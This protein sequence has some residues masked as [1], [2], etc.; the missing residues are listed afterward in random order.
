MLPVMGVNHAERLQKLIDQE[1]HRQHGAVVSLEGKEINMESLYIA[2]RDA[3]LGV[4]SNLRT[5][6]R[7]SREF[8]A[9]D[10]FS[11]VAFPVQVPNLSILTAI[12]VVLGIKDGMLFTELLFQ[13]KGRA[14]M[15]Y[16]S[17]VHTGKFAL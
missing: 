2:V 15:V 13:Y 4:I 9:A 1:E 16:T 8:S 10:D 14:A 17:G 11:F 7:L 5:M 3:Y 12:D 6:G